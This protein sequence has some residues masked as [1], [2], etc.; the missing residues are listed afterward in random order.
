MSPQVAFFL[1]G[2]SITLN[3]QTGSYA[4]AY[5]FVPRYPCGSGGRR[6]WSAQANDRPFQSA[7]HHLANRCDRLDLEIRDD[8]RCAT[9]RRAPFCTPGPRLIPENAELHTTNERLITLIISYSFI[10]MK[11]RKRNRHRKNESNGMDS[12]SPKG[13]RDATLEFPHTSRKRRSPP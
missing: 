1:N 12:S 10:R 11:M 4:P 6:P 13:H 9:A 5:E 7:H 2:S 3:F 8:T